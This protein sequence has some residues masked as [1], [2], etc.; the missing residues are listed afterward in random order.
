[1]TRLSVASLRDPAPGERE[2]GD[3]VGSL[4]LPDA[5][6]TWLMVVDGLGH[7]PP[8]ALAAQ[9]AM[10]H[11]LV[12][13]TDPDLL[14]QPAAALAGLEPALRDTRGAAVGLVCV[15]RG[16]LVHAGIGNTRCRLWRG[17]HMKGL[18]SVYGIAGAF[19][20]HGASGGAGVTETRMALQPGDWVL[21]FSDGLAENIHMDVVPG[22]WSNE[23]GRLCD[24]L[25]QR[26][27]VPRDDAAVLAACVL[28]A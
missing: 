22:E 23:P 5:D 4:T 26:W 12:T 20:G 21:M 1:M 8:A 6:A 9:A 28:R 10:N 17:G 7:G 2:C 3:W 25:M 14:G 15:Q 18:H 27:R 24:H 11:L 16:E 13:L 19:S